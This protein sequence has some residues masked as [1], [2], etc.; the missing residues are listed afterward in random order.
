VI[1]V[2]ADS[3]N[4]KGAEKKGV[5]KKGATEEIDSKGKPKEKIVVKKEE[6]EKKEKKSKK[7]KKDK[8]E[9]KE[10]KDKSKKKELRSDQAEEKAEKEKVQKEKEEKEEKKKETAREEIVVELVLLSRSHLHHLLLLR[11]LHC[12][13]YN[14][15]DVF[16]Y[17]HLFRPSVGVL[18][19][20]LGA[21]RIANLAPSPQ[22]SIH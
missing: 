2:S 5:E 1:D 4:E 20:T 11:F 19:L 10:K 22:E 9:K 6:K 13:R 12:Q 15:G 21:L 18:H 8:K 7:G 14:L 3:D 16:Y 17:S